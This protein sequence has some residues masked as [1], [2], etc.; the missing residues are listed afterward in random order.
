MTVGKINGFLSPAQCRRLDTLLEL[1]KDFSKGNDNAVTHN[2]EGLLQHLLKLGKE[3]WASDYVQ[4]KI[5]IIENHILWKQ[6][7]EVSQ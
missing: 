6:Q 2:L 3:P 7:K 4:E 1:L 5:E